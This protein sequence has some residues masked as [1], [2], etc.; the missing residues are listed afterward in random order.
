MRSTTPTPESPDTIR[1]PRTRNMPYVEAATRVIRQSP[2]L[3]MTATCSAVLHIFADADEPL[4]PT[5]IQLA[6]QSRGIEFDVTSIRRLLVKLQ[7]VR[8]IIPVG[9]LGGFVRRDDCGGKAGIPVVVVDTF[10]RKTR[11]LASSPELVT[12]IKHLIAVHELPDTDY[13]IQL[14]AG[15]S[16]DGG[17]N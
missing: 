12:A 11:T 15:T 5:H 8:A 2:D 16:V 9:A 7:D 17:G 3:Y 4:K 1:V 14:V 10:D 6:L 13:C